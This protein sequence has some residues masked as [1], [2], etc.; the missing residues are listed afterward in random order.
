MARRKDQ[1]KVTEEGYIIEEYDIKI[2]LINEQTIFGTI[3]IAEYNVDRISELFTK[4]ESPYIVVYNCTINDEDKE[5][6]VL[7]INKSN[8]LWIEPLNN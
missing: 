8:V 2:K 5:E 3:N 6:K 7:F 1:L 4:A